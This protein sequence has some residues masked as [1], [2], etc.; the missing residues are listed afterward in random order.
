[1]ANYTGIGTQDDPWI[2]SDWDSF[3]EL[4]PRNKRGDG[5]SGPSWIKWA[6][7]DN[8]LIDFNVINPDGY[9]SMDILAKVDFNDWTF[10]NYRVIDN[11]NPAF[12]MQ[13]KN[14]LGWNGEIKNG[15]FENLLLNSSN[16]V[17]MD[18]Q[19]CFC[20]NISATGNI[21]RTNGDIVIVFGR[22]SNVKCPMVYSS[23]FVFDVQ[24]TTYYASCSV[25]A[26][27][28]DCYFKINFQG[29]GP[30]GCTSHAFED[31]NTIYEI[32]APNSSGV[33]LAF[34]GAGSSISYPSSSRN[35]VYI[36]ETKNIIRDTHSRHATFNN[37]I[38]NSDL[39][40][41]CFVA[42]GLIPCTTSQIV[43]VEYLKSIGF[44]AEH[45]EEGEI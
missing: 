7:T 40:E 3:I 11:D 5:S 38:Y 45:A 35:C 33:T 4:A 29:T 43:D 27:T 20:R 14:D 37:S 42:D 31:T 1:M 8:K 12:T 18:G 26:T 19:N 44:P 6:E 28:Q 25:F 15:N 36:I 17:A 30:V 13:S 9:K 22:Q 23:S 34:Y 41:S 2:V 16:F 32:N 39:V 10:R 24:P 21:S